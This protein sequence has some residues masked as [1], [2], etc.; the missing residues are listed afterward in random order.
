MA[1]DSLRFDYSA[2]SP[3]PP[4]KNSHFLFSPFFFFSLGF[5]G[6]REGGKKSI[7]RILSIFNKMKYPYIF[8]WLK[9][10]RGGGVLLWGVTSY[11]RDTYVKKSRTPG[12]KKFNFNFC[13]LDVH[14]Y[15]TE[16]TSSYALQICI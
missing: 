4:Q 11:V 5:R 2:P 8:F 3:Q 12:K 7:T 9:K 16:Y 13:V 15:H 6:G 1:R 14:T 10:K